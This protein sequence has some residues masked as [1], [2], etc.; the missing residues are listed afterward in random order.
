MQ[1]TDYEL[2]A[3]RVPPHSIEAEHSVLGGL[4][5]D[6]R[7][8]DRIGDVISAP[9]FY[10]YDHRLI[11]EAIISLIDA[12]K[13]ADVI[14]V[15]EQLVGRGKSDDCGGL[16]YLNAMAQSTPSAAN[17]TRYAE[18]V[19]NRGI[20]RRLIIAANEI[21]DDAYRPAGKDVMAIL[22]EAEAKILA[23]AESRARKIE[24]AKPL[25]PLL[26]EVVERI[27]ALYS[28]EDQ[29]EVTGI[30]TGFTDLDRMTTGLQPGDLVVVAGRPSM[31][32]TA[33]AINIGEHVCLAAQL[34]V[35]V[36]SMEM[37]GVQL[38][39][40]MLGSVGQLDQQRLRTGRLIDEDWP[41][42][43]HAIQKLNDV[44]VH[45]DE[46]GSLTPVELR[47]RAR[48]L[49]RQHGQLGLV[50]VDYL[51][52]MVGSSKGQGGSDNRATELAEISRSLKGLA[53]ELKCPVIALSQ[54]N[55]TLESRPN[56]RPIMSD[57]RESGA[58][59]QDADVILFLYRDEVYNPD[60]TDKGIAEVIIGK[61]RNGP[62]GTV[63]LTW[64]GEYTKFGNYG[65]SS[66]R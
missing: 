38:A 8:W 58:I 1:T 51:Q 26:T 10:R 48:R 41:R 64:M 55:R 22:D 4:M 65:V 9:D 21:C 33:M 37:G 18:I 56:K 13:P 52:L 40:R 2:E 46:T 50:I 3:L 19:R 63:R 49:A 42:L 60:S 66:V 23:I 11:F 28:R 43:T 31:G 32:K 61:Q 30:P 5:T 45:I 62:T 12:N 27:D 54:L 59:E 35:V 34:P 36:F 25:Q 7:A 15:H 24:G 14:T 44:S 53:K 57:I 16:V 29:S 17:I 6:N 20:L 47:A 39:S